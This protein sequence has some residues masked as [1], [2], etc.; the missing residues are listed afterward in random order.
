MML[1][2]T[3]SHFSHFLLYHIPQYFC[4]FFSLKNFDPYDHYVV[5]R[6]PLILLPIHN[7]TL[8]TSLTSD[9]SCPGGAD[10]GH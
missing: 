8:T 3:F 2:Q 5:C 6:V 1:K 7:N 10:D 4:F 9:L